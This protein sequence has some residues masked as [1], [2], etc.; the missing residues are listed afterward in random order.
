MEFLRH[1][2]RHKPDI[3]LRT[4]AVHH[5]DMV[6]QVLAS[7]R[8]IRITSNDITHKIIHLTLPTI[9]DKIDH[10]C[11]VTGVTNRKVLMVLLTLEFPRIAKDH[12]RMHV[13]VL[14]V[15]T[16]LCLLRTKCTEGHRKVRR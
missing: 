5:L 16:M 7:F 6:F 8:S 4:M 14:I 2:D 3:P 12:T 1:R 10:P 11:R 9:E 13:R 15:L